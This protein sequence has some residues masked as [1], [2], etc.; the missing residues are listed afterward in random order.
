M[1]TTAN[2]VD[3]LVDAELNNIRDGRVLARLRELRIR[4]KPIKRGWDYGEPD[5]MHLCWT[6]LEHAESNTGIAYCGEGFGPEHPWGLIFISGDHMNMG[7]DS[8][9]FKSLEA[10]L[11]D[12]MA[13]DEEVPLDSERS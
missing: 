7:M 10:A 8:A 6:V 2:D 3:E 12:S 4:P 1:P 11:L 13:W 5:Q 9:W